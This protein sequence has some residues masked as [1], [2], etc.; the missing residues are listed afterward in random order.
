MDEKTNLP[1]RV[2]AEQTGESYRAATFLKNLRPRGPWVV[3]SIHD[4]TVRS[5]QFSSGQQG[6]MAKWIMMRQGRVN[7]YWHIN[8]TYSDPGNKAALEDVSHVERLHVDIDPNPNAGIPLEDQRAAILSALTDRA[9]L[10]QLGLPGAP[11]IIIDSGGGYWAF[12]NLVEPYSLDGRDAQERRDNAHRV[13]GHNK[14][15]AKK[16]NEALGTRYADDCHNVDRVARLPW[17]LNI[18]TAKKRAQGRTNAVASVIK[19]DDGGHYTLDQ[20]GWEDVGEAG[21]CREAVEAVHV[22]EGDWSPLPGGDAWEAVQELIRRYPEVRPKTTEL[23]LLGNYLHPE[24]EGVPT[25]AEDGAEVVDRNAI[26]H[27]VNRALQQAG[28]PLGLVI[29]ILKDRRFAVSEHARFPANKG[30]ISRHELGGGDLHRF[31]SNQVRKAAAKLAQEAN[32]AKIAARKLD[33][34]TLTQAEAPSNTAEASSPRP[35]VSSSGPRADAE[36]AEGGGAAPPGPPPP[37]PPGGNGDDYMPQEMRFQLP[38]NGGPPLKNER[39]ILVALRR[40]GVGLSYN[41]FADRLLIEGLEGFGPELNDAAVT[42][43]WLTID[44]TFGFRPTKSYF[45]DVLTNA[46]L[47]NSFH[48]IF[49]YFATLEW[50]GTP[51]LDT[52][53][54]RYGGAK[55]TPYVRAISRLTLLAAVR[56]LRVPGCK[57]DEMPVLEGLQG[58]N[59]SSALKILAVNDEWFTDDL[60]LG[61]SSK[62]LIEQ[63][64]G[65]WIIEIAD[66]HKRGR[67]EINKVKAQLSRT[68]DRARLAYGKLAVSVKRQFVFFSTTNEEKYLEDPTG[69]RRFWP[70]FTQRFDLDALTQDR[71]QLWAEAVILEQRGESI[72]MDASL[73][74]EAAI[75]Q[76]KRS[77]VEIDPWY[78]HLDELLGE[79]DGKILNSDIWRLVGLTPDK[80]KRDDTFRIANV[81]RRLGFAPASL[82]FKVNGINKKHRG[83]VRG[84]D[85]DTREQ[86]LVVRITDSGVTITLMSLE[87][88]VAQ[89]GHQYQLN[90]HEV[91]F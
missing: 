60:P 16:L 68:E 75:E 36:P 35:E 51:R 91:P 65:K 55:D 42:S 77:V 26:F 53:L 24:G 87:E 58:T 6:A 12:W 84:E 34:A 23:I 10:V 41:R 81:M 3:T 69:E 83:F 33:E 86:Q 63:L 70:V 56:R 29:E 1:G 30:V 7:L 13:G 85:A 21:P 8:P 17:V 22:S 44:R 4:G 37:P 71:D 90:G 11:N 46:A 32:N 89:G 9:R 20:F 40:L 67:P 45:Y 43:L 39:N 73:W 49:D 25:K 61:A 66:L 38:E 78:E 15:L 28:V 2:A 64:T 27:R 31:V 57:F 72:R 14:W 59:K 48:P 82:R 74:N 62:E 88:Q 76:S 50:D 5:E 19:D 47:A 52:W 80:M 79:R 18:P 54:I